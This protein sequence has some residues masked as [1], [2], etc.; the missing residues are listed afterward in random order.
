MKFKFYMN[1]PSLLYEALEKGANRARE[2]AKL[3]LAEIKKRIGYER[4]R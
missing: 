1:A 3:N 4:E 2:I